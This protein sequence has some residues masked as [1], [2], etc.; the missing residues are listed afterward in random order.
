[1][2]VQKIYREFSC[3][4]PL[5]YEYLEMLKVLVKTWQAKLIKVLTSFVYFLKKSSKS[6]DNFRK[7][8][9]VSYGNTYTQ[10][11]PAFKQTLILIQTAFCT[12]SIW[13][14]LYR[15]NRIDIA[16]GWIHI[17]LTLLAY[18]QLWKIKNFFWKLWILKFLNNNFSMQKI[19]HICPDTIRLKNHLCIQKSYFANNIPKGIQ[20]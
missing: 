19:A 7:T 4:E 13:R 5:H 3:E 15:K 1:M 2:I 20:I 9:C 10:K 14:L 6:F 17:V 11:K 18:I 8:F 12:W 16:N